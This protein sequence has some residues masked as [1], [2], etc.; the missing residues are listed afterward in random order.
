MAQKRSL[1]ITHNLF[2]CL[3]TYLF[4]YLFIYAFIVLDI[5][6]ELR[7]IVSNISMSREHRVGKA[8][9]EAIELIRDSGSDCGADGSCLQGYDSVSLGEQYRTLRIIM[10]YESSGLNSSRRRLEAEDEDNTNL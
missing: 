5:G 1:Y 3:C 6:Q 10:L 7:A 2:I 9:K 8:M 4:I